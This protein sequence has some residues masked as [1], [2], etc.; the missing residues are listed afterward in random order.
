MRLVL[1]FYR[2]TTKTESCDSFS[3]L[4]TRSLRE[5]GGVSGR[6]IAKKRGDG[7]D[8]IPHLQRKGHHKEPDTGG[9]IKQQ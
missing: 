1:N 3:Q 9:I 7:G 5:R 4:S 8:E 6:H 2:N